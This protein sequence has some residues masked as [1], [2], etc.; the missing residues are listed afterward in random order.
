[1]ANAS[2]PGVGGFLER[3]D[4]TAKTYSNIKTLAGAVI[5]AIGVVFAAGIYYS[6]LKHRLD[7]YVNRM[8]ALE[9]TVATLNQKLQAQASALDL[10]KQQIRGAVNAAL[11]RLLDVQNSGPPFTNTEPANNGGGFSASQP[12]GRCQPGQVVV[13]IQPYKEGNGIRS[14]IMQCGTLPRVQVQ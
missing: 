12:P 7:D 10:E 14:I 9:T 6:E 11:T 13:G 4:R 8:S 2:K 1:M 5:T 3:L